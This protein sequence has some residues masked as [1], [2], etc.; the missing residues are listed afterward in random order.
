MRPWHGLPERLARRAT[1]LAFLAVAVVSVPLGI[2]APPSGYLALEFPALHLADV[3]DPLSWAS[4][5]R[6]DAFLGLGLDFL[7]LVLYPLWLS[8]ACSLAA[9]RRGPATRLGSVAA[10]A[11]A[12]VW[13]AAP[14]DAAEN[15]G[16]YFWLAGHHDVGLAFAISLVAGAK[17]LVALGAA[18]IALVVTTANRRAPQPSTASPRPPGA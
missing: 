1:W 2:V 12:W 16:I 13:S 15:V 11:S 18:G 14:L 8:L 3:T 9:R 10:A 6:E 5:A 17:W 7:F 4:S